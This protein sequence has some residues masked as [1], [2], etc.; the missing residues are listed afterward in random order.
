LQTEGLNLCNAKLRLFELTEVIILHIKGLQRQVAKEQRLE[1]KH[2][3]QKLNSFTRL[4]L[5]F[6]KILILYNIVVKDLKKFWMKKLD[7]AYW[8]VRQ[9]ISITA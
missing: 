4:F 6:I 7:T 8:E 1:K 5:W 2:L 3:W 9:A